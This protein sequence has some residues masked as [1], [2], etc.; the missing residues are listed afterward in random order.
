[1]MRFGSALLL[2]AAVASAEDDRVA[3][4]VRDKALQKQIHVAIDSGVAV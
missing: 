2:L 4:R 1:M 3:V